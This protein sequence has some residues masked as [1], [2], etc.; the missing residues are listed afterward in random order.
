MLSQDSIYGRRPWSALREQQL[1]DAL[2]EWTGT[3][4]DEIRLLPPPVPNIGLRPPRYG[5]AHH[6]LRVE[7]IVRLDDLYPGS[8]VDN[9][10][11]R[12][13]LPTVMQPIKGV[14]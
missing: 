5:Y 6:V 11:R 7:D 8:R 2:G 13:G 3:P 4:A 14:M 12:S 1:S 10:A 9:S